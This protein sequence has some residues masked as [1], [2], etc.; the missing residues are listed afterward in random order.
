[1]E[2]DLP[3]MEFWLKLWHAKVPFWLVFLTWVAFA[4]YWYFFTEDADDDDG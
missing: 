2:S 3:M 1:M 4:A